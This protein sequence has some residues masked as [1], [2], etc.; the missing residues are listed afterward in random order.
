M[1]LAAGASLLQA[2]AHQALET[3]A[4]GFIQG[5]GAGTGLLKP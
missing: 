4:P 3:A 5:Q 1:Q 2:A